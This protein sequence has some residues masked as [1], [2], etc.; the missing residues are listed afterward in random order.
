MAK[1]S[2]CGNQLKP[3]T[4]KLYAK[5]DGKIYYFCCNKCEKNMLKLKRKPL[6]TKWTK[7]FKRQTK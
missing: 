1:C 7:Y 3:G 5:A 6:Q 2:F 4:G